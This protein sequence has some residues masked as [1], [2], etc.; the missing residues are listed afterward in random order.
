ML[1]MLKSS[2]VIVLV[3][4]MSFVCAF[5]IPTLS[6]AEDATGK[7]GSA[8]SGD[9]GSAGAAAGAGATEGATTDTWA[10]VALIVAVILAGVAAATG[11]G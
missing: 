11:G 9:T 7:E 1:R 5:V 2:R 8:A 6:F 4:M 3:A 10:W